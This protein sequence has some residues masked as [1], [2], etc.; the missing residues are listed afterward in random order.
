MNKIKV[1]IADD[2]QLI[3]SAI[4][5]LLSPERFEFAGEAADGNELVKLYFNTSPDVMLVD[6]NMPH[7]SGLAAVKEILL[8][9]PD[10]TALL[11][12][13]NSEE[14]DIYMA[15]SAGGRGLISKAVTE[16]ELANSI[17]KVFEGKLCFGIDWN[18]E[19]LKE[20]SVKHGSSPYGS[21]NDIK[22]LLTERE[23]EIFYDYGYGLDSQAIAVKL[24]VSNKTIQTHRGNIMEK[25][26][27]KKADELK[28]IAAEFI[29]KGLI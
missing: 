18:R 5:G 4:K 21:Y 8:L 7:K 23:L 11:L 17:I 19:K 14:Q 28:R 12:S 27:I 3:R 10:A 13:I 26:N 24:F 29:R 25:L 22:K 9:E 15:Y 20:L 1:I 16:E 6:I 2:H